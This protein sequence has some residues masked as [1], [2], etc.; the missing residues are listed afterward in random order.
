MIT[1]SQLHSH[2]LKAYNKKFRGATYATVF[3]GI[4]QFVTTFRKMLV[5][6]ETLRAH[7]HTL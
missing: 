7:S 3:D 1:C 2:N 5:N 6:I 4:C